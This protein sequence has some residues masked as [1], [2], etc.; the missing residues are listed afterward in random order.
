MGFFKKKLTKES[1]NDMKLEVYESW[2]EGIITNSEKNL[3][4]NYINESVCDK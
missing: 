1:A 2:N 3:M 4:I